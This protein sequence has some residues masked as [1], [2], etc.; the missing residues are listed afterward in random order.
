MTKKTQI[1]VRCSDADKEL[2]I[3]VAKLLRRSQSDTR[4]LNLAYCATNFFMPK[5]CLYNHDKTQLNQA[6]MSEEKS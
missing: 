4:V 1:A 5:Q 2:L 3:K 6:C